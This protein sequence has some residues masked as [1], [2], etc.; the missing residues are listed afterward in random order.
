MNM[1]DMFG[2]LTDFQNKLAQIKEELQHIEVNAESGGGMVK[3]T[4][5]GNREVTSINIDPE[6]VNPADTEILEDLVIAAV[7]QAMKK[8]E[9]AGQQKMGE[10]TRGIIPGG[11]DLGSL[12]LR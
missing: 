12:G 2:K 4:A 8:S 3:V 5:N 10:L 7:N 1:A 6:L 11:L 9:E